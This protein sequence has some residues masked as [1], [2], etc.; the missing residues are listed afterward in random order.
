MRAALNDA[1]LSATA[2]DM[3]EPETRSAT[4]VCRAGVSTAFTRPRSQGED[5]EVPELGVAEDEQEAEREAEHHE[6]RS[7]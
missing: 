6:R 2:F 3:F 1:E 7:A 5:V 4:K